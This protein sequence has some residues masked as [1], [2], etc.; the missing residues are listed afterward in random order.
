MV[1][2]LS[3]PCDSLVVHKKTQVVSRQNVFQL[4]S[5]LKNDSI[6]PRIVLQRLQ[7]C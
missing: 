7:A 3:K 4:R 6:I 1:E 2:Y 5:T